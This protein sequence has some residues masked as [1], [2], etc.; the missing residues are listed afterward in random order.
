M[1]VG[2]YKRTAA[3]KEK[4][5]LSRIGKRHSLKTIKKIRQSKIGIKLTIK[6]RRKL[7][8][9]KLGKKNPN[10]NGGISPLIVRIRNSGKYLSWK[11]LILERDNNRCVICRNRKN[12]EVDHIIP[13]AYLIRRYKINTLN[14][15]IDNINL[16]SVH[17]GRVLCK[18]CHRQGDTF[19]WNY[20]HNVLRKL[21]KKTIR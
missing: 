12:V 13:L 15:A 8:R 1:P 19:G 14:K 2:V 4:I 3:T 20:Y 18:K 7:S 21:D 9:A 16:W 6:H 11:E 5:R 10:W 17:N